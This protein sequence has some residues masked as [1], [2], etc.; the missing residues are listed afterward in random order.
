M[1]PA[2]AP[3]DSGVPALSVAL[4]ATSDVAPD[5]SAVAVDEAD[6][7]AEPVPAGMVEFPLTMGVTIEPEGATGVAVG[8]T[9]TEVTEAVSVTRVLG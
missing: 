7:E 4:P 5:S 2:A 3:V 9:T 8:T 6:S 1:L